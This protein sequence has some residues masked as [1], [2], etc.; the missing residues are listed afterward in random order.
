MQNEVQ[1]LDSRIQKI[2]K[3]VELPST[4]NEIKDQM[5]DFLKVS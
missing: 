2:K 5:R 4:E 1:A 3:Q